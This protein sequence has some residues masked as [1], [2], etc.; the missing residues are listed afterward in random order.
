MLQKKRGR[1]LHELAHE[2][3]QLEHS[4]DLVSEEQ[5]NNLEEHVHKEL[6][7]LEEIDEE[8]HTLESDPHA[9]NPEC[10]FVTFQ[11]R[12]DVLRAKAA[13]PNSSIT[14]YCCQHSDPG[15]LCCSEKRI[16]A[17]VPP[18]NGIDGKSVLSEWD[19][20]TGGDVRRTSCCGDKDRF[21]RTYLA[22]ST[23][24]PD[25][26]KWENLS[27]G[28]TNRCCRLLLSSLITLIMLG[29]TIGVGILIKN[30]I[31]KQ[32][33]L[34]PTVD[35]QAAAQTLPGGV[36][37]Q[38]DAILDELKLQRSNSTHFE[39]K[40]SK[41][42]LLGCYCGGIDPRELSNVKFD[43]KT[44]AN[45]TEAGY[46]DLPIEF[47]DS[48]VRFQTYWCLKWL[49]DA[50]TKQLYG[51]AS[52]VTIVVV[53]AVL[54]VVMKRLVAM[55]RPMSQSGFST[56]LMTKLTVFQFLNTALVTMLVNANL[57]DFNTGD[58]DYTLGG[59]L[60]NGDY[61]DFTKGWHLQIG[62]ALL[63]TMIINLSTP[64]L[65]YWFLPW[66]GKAKAIAKDRTRCCLCFCCCNQYRKESKKIT[67][68]EYE[69]L[70]LGTAFG[71][72]SRYAMVN[73][74]TGVSLVFGPSTPL[75]YV[76]AMVYLMLHYWADK[77][78]FVSVIKIPERTDG[79]FYSRGFIHACACTS[80]YISMHVRHAKA[81]QGPR[82]T[83]TF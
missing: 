59:L 9:K 82:D 25:N 79:K 69:S 6:F 5:L 41:S 47:A 38:S 51:V 26:L 10:A 36:I 21:Y 80:T 19:T 27:I 52:V 28:K 50:T 63:L 13:Y 17:Y 35:C 73:M 48:S 45:L 68:G 29:L 34:Y 54:K 60:F 15:R 24:G 31:I 58:N 49:N 78:N 33:R 14:Y 43:L 72:E 46:T 20:E 16:K 81:C 76:F 7:R 8:I 44:V 64:I 55:E 65:Y 3:A 37:T 11:K 83:S 66:C 62:T 39:E 18:M 71:L 77:F 70:F 61:S 42:S 74:V 30:E 2:L 23:P 53:N 1:L 67:Q 40:N 22:E 75:L 12:E 32:S 56:S 57:N 4:H